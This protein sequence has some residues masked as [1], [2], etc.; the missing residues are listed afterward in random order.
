MMNS[1]KVSR[2]CRMLLFIFPALL[3]ISGQRRMTAESPQHDVANADAPRVDFAEIDTLMENA[4]AKGRI[5]GA[6]VLVGH[7]GRIVYRKAFGS[8]SL[9]PTHETMTVDTIFDMASLTKC[10]VT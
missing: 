9:E 1:W 4:V 6:V 3:A 7:N 2:H 8:R 5:P 10:I